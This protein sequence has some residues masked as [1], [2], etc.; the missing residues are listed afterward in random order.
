[1][2]WQNGTATGGGTLVVDTT[3]RRRQRHQPRTAA[4]SASFSPNGD[5]VRDTVATTVSVPEAG[6]IVDLGAERRRHDRPL[7]G[8]RLDRRRQRRG[9]GRPGAN[10]AVVPD[11]DYTVHFVA[12]DRRR[13]E[14]RRKSRPV[15]V[16]SLL[17][18]VTDVAQG[19]LPAGQRPVA[20]KTGLSFTLARPATVTWT[21]RNAANA[22]VAT[23]L[24]DAAVGAGTQTWIWDGQGRRRAFAAAGIY[25]SL[26]H[27][28]RR[29]VGDQPVRQGRDERVRDLDLD[30]DSRIAAASM[31]VTVTSAEPLSAASCSTSPSPASPSGT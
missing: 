6:S 23:H 22:V 31:T 2:P 12:R 25:T 24:D 3:A 18:H 27:R 19:L 15:R 10:G 11:G 1:M 17:G 8:R 13:H 4:R 9:L 21:I 5:G 26:R 29:D 16:I 30:R 28:R 14:R 20:P 7:V